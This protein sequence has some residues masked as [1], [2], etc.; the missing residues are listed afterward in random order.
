MENILFLGGTDCCRNRVRL[1]WQLSHPLCASYMTGYFRHGNREAGLMLQALLFLFQLPVLVW[2]THF[3]VVK[4]LVDTIT[5]L[6]MCH[7]ATILNVCF[8]MYESS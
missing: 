1:L 5:S 7:F 2:G 3:Q 6:S 4:V 8:S